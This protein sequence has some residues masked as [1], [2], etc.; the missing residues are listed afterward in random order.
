MQSDKFYNTLSSE[1]D[2]MI[3][4]ES[5]LNKRYNDI[6]NYIPKNNGKAVDI[7]CGTGLDTIAM[8]KLGYSMT[9]FDISDGMIEK[10]KENANKLGVNVDFI[11]SPAHKIDNK[12]DKQFD[13]AISLGN[14]IANVEKE[15]F[16]DTISVISQLLKDNGLVLIQVLNYKK[17]LDEKNRIVNITKSE[18]RTFIRF[19]DFLDENIRFNILSFNSSDL[20]DK[21]LISTL[22]YPYNKDDFNNELMKNGFNNVDFYSDFN[23]NHFDEESSKDLIIFA[24]K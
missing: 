1:Y 3:D 4:F 9:G 23:K 19:Y 24:S 8:S 14:S 20:S 16:A 18:K 2:S 10:A 15:Y 17:I 5:L 21:N 6:S 11:V 13:V 12:F 7:G 22:L